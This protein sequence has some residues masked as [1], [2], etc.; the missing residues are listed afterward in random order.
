[1]LRK[2]SLIVI[3]TIFI[4]AVYAMGTAVAAKVSVVVTG[5]S[6]TLTPSADSTLTAVVLDGT[7]QATTGSLAQLTV[8]D[9]RG[10]GVGW[11]LTT[12]ATN[13][14]EI[15]DAAK[16]IANTGFEVTAVNLV[17]VSG[18]GGVNGS[19]GFIDTPLTLL[20]SSS[21]NGMGTYNS[22]PDLSLQVPAETYVGTYAS[23]VTETLTSY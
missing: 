16:T 14:E 6:L 10:T 19:T 7:D 9:A 20:D 17:T 13:F 23:T 2:L 15:N 21:P 11:N 5:G 12:S 18:N 3:V 22:T 4:V 1:M 8:T